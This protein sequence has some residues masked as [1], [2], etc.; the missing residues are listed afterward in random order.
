MRADLGW[1]YA[2][3]GLMNA[4]NAAGYLLGALITPMLL[5]R[6]YAGAVLVAGSVA[7]TVLTLTDGGLFTDTGLWLAQRLAAGVASAVV[8]VTGGLLAARLERAGS[9]AAAAG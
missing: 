9:Q 8:F 7:A 4:A 5:R 3:S 1:S 6:H 2:L